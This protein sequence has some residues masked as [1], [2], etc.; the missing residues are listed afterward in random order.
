[1]AA[2]AVVGMPLP[3]LPPSARQLLLQQLSC[4]PQVLTP[5]LLRSRIRDAVKAAISA[6]ND[7]SRANIGRLPGVTNRYGAVLL[8]YCVSDI[9]DGEPSLLGQLSGLSLLPMRDGSLAAME[10]RKGRTKPF[11][12]EDGKRDDAW[13]LFFA[14]EAGEALL[15]AAPQLIV[16]RGVL[17]SDL[18]AT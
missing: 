13:P 9:S 15:A 14:D 5:H 16:Y 3:A 2:L 17:G 10:L 7:Q 12:A 8:Q 4:A 11:A 6:A 1:M 18:A